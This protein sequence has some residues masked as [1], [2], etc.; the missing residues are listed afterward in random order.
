MEVSPQAALVMWIFLAATTGTVWIL[1]QYGR[2]LWLHTRTA[3]IQILYLKQAGI[4]SIDD[5]KC[6]NVGRKEASQ[7]R[8]DEAQS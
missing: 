5:E 1:L 4:L 8:R 6:D 3:Y 7:E 2:K